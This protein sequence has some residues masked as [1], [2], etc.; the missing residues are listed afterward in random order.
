MYFSKCNY[1][2]CIFAKCTWLACLLSFASLFLQ[3]SPKIFAHHV[4]NFRMI[5]HD[6]NDINLVFNNRAIILSLVLL[7]PP[8]SPTF[9]QP[10]P[11]SL[12]CSFKFCYWPLPIY[13]YQYIEFVLTNLKMTVR[14][15]MV[16]SE[17]CN[18]WCFCLGSKIQQWQQHFYFS[19]HLTFY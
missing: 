17:V 1:P 15:T 18:A 3:K 6:I 14:G 16:R 12:L 7:S 8:L 2:K 10:S 11:A 9:L 4:R 13:K 5:D 19:W